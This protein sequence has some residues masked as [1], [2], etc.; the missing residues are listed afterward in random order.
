[1]YFWQFSPSGGDRPRVRERE[2]G[3]AENVKCCRRYWWR[4]H[5][6]SCQLQDPLTTMEKRAF[7]ATLPASPALTSWLGAL[8]IGLCFIIQH[9]F[10]LHFDLSCTSIK[11]RCNKSYW[12]GSWAHVVLVASGWLPTV[13]VLWALPFFCFSASERSINDYGPPISMVISVG[14]SDL[15]CVQYSAIYG[16]ALLQYGDPMKVQKI[17]DSVQSLENHS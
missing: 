13:C 16:N 12:M 9:L 2:R 3:G 15:I 14:S 8:R 7:L 4:G 6:L 5:R 17:I 1:M 10:W 11:C